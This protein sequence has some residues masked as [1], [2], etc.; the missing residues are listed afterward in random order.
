MRQMYFTCIKNFKHESIADFEKRCIEV[1]GL[2][3]TDLGFQLP[4]SCSQ[5]TKTGTE[6][7]LSLSKLS[8]HTN[9]MPFLTELTCTRSTYT[10]GY[11]VESGLE[12]ETLPQG[13]RDS[14]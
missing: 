9:G 6:M 8:F 14:S 7:T 12:P 5:L 11:L 3:L 13:H 4:I 2:G 10:S 1:T